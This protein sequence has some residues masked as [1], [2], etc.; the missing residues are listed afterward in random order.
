MLVTDQDSFVH[1]FYSI[2]DL[3][4]AH[5]LLNGLWKQAKTHLPPSEIVKGS[6]SHIPLRQDPQTYIY[7]YSGRAQAAAP[8][9][10][11]HSDRPRLRALQCGRRA[12]TSAQ[13]FR[14]A[15]SIAWPS[16]RS[17]ETATDAA[18]AAAAAW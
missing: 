9:S 17:E 11:P 1:R 2:T 7:C 8:P 4:T 5:Q 18:A 13:G 6:I 15:A 14:C 10:P 3:V 16:K 12:I